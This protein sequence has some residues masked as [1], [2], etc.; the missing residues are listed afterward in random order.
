[1]I[2]IEDVSPVKSR[3]TIV[4]GGQSFSGRVTRIVASADGTRL[5]GASVSG[6]WRSDDGGF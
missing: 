4:F 1:M 3:T 2:H 6:V 5:Y